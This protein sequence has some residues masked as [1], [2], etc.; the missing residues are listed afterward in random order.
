MTIKIIFKKP[1]K[2]GSRIFV[3]FDVTQLTLFNNVL[4]IISNGNLKTFNLDVI[5]SIALGEGGGEKE[6]EVP[7]SD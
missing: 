1:V 3:S 5:K 6:C 4:S 2:Y 7:L